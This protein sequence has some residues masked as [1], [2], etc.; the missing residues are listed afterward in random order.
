M[1][2]KRKLDETNRG[3]MNIF[4]IVLLILGC[5][6]FL[7]WLTHNISYKLI[8]RKILESGKWGLN[9]CCGKTDGGGVNADIVRHADVS[10][11]VVLKDIYQLP[12][13]DGE[14]ENVL[15]SHTMEH[16]DDPVR[17]FKELQRVGKNVTVVIPPLWDFFNAIS[18]FVHKWF[19]LTFR[20]KHVNS[21]PKFKRVPLSRFV[22]KHFGQT[23]NA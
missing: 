6:V 3:D 14:F 21:L 16:V 17:F 13:K 15:C 7:T 20:K 9:I 19:F 5:I 1:C 18:P 2:Y 8:K 4:L 10:R 12:F 11:F 23:I 22:H